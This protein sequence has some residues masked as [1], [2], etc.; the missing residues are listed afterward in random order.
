[1][2]LRQSS[3]PLAPV[4]MAGAA[5]SLLEGC[6]SGVGGV[7]LVARSARQRGTLGSEE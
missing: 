5:A 2:V 3:L 6:W 1:M 7:G 4:W